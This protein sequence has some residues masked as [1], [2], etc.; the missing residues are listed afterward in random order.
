MRKGKQYD[1]EKINID[2]VES[3]NKPNSKDLFTQMLEVAREETEGKT[4]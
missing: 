3:K 4:I 2:K 1:F